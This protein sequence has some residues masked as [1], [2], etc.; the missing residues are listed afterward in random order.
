MRAGPEAVHVPAG[1]G[2]AFG[3]VG[4]A[5]TI[6]ADGEQTGGAYALLEARG[7]PGQGPPPHVHRR[8]D[9]AFYVIEGTILF[10]AD[11]RETRAGAG[12]YVYLPRGSVHRFQNIGEGDARMLVLV[13][14]SG[15]EKFI[16]EVG[17]PLE[18]F[19]DPPPPVTGEQ[20]DRLIAVA[21]QYGIE[22]Q[23]PAD[24]PVG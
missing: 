3:V 17:V 14:P 21:P 18:R 9:E 23:I 15:F 5:Y 8:E 6:L 12:G 7:P 24:P 20:I 11:G 1:S 10:V 19:S 4:D 13:A 16:A 2:R 22:I